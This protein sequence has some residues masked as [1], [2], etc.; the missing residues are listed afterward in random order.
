[1]HS[2][3]DAK[4][5]L[6]DCFISVIPSIAHICRCSYKWSWSRLVYMEGISCFPSCNCHYSWVN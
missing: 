4:Q 1:M 6:V 2:N 3:L 5:S